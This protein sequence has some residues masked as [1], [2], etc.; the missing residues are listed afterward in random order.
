MID[1]SSS[2]LAIVKTILVKYVPDREVWA[3][4]SRVTGKAR[5]T[6]DLDIAVMGKTKLNRNALVLMKEEFE[7]STLPF[8]VDI[9]DWNSISEDF[10]KHILADHSVLQFPGNAKKD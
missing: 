1:L 2:E 9:L 7:E 8:T 5:P 10:Q 3:F 6:S 4:G